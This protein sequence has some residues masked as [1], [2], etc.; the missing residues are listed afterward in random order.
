MIEA[1]YSSD[2][3]GSA[4]A[5]PANCNRPPMISVAPGG[6]LSS[7]QASTLQ[8]APPQVSVVIPCLNEEAAVGAVVDQAWQG[9]EASG[10]S[11]EVIVVD[12]GSTDRSAEIAA[13]HGATVISEPHRGYGSAYLAG[14]ARAR[15]E[16][17]V[18]GD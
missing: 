17:V 14:L 2:T 1:A 10:R 5:P 12:N 3:T 15:G 11:G 18:M 7:V 9:I 4:S 16:Y 8:A 6:I 13:E